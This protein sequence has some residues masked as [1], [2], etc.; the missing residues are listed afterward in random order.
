M[1]EAMKAIADER[2]TPLEDNPSTWAEWQ[3]WAEWQIAEPLNDFDFDSVDCCRG[4][5]LMQLGVPTNYSMFRP[6]HTTKHPM[7]RLVPHD[8]I[9]DALKLIA[10]VAKDE[11]DDLEIDA[12]GVNLLSAWVILKMTA[13]REIVFLWDELEYRR[14]RYGKARS[15]EAAG[16]LYRHD[17]RKISDAFLASTD[18]R[19]AAML[20]EAGVP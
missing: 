7:L 5:L 16:E 4:K 9:V 14:K 18:E 8:E 3:A 11:F 19:R 20:A 17:C 15:D 10:P 6:M 1:R 13:Q 2:P 12:S